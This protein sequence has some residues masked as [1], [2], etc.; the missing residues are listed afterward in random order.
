[1]IH[2]TAILLRRALYCICGVCGSLR[3]RVRGVRAGVEHPFSTD[4]FLRRAPILARTPG[5]DTP[6]LWLAVGMAPA[7]VQPMLAPPVD[8]L[9]RV[10]PYP[11]ARATMN[12]V[13][14]RGLAPAGT[15]IVIHLY[16]G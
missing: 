15:P 12:D 2:T 1:M 13:R 14:L 5:A 10:T 3:P 9:K 8:H 11:K 6:S 16:T 4:T 7:G